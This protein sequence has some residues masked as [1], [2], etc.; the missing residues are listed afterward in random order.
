[1]YI[2]VLYVEWRNSVGT[3]VP[4][5]DIGKTACLANISDSCDAIP[6][7]PAS[8]PVRLLICILR[9]SFAYTRA[10]NVVFLF[11]H[12]H[13]K[14]LAHDLT[15]VSLSSAVKNDTICGIIV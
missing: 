1:M 14:L 12:H 11:A 8:L 3:T 5:S 13:C 15:P 9:I 4:A 6:R 7:L 10:I 2:C